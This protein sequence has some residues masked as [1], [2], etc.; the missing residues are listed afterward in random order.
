M[1]S[2]S[3]QAMILLSI[4][5]PCDVD[6]T[7]IHS[8]VTVQSYVFYCH[9]IAGVAHK[10]IIWIAINQHSGGVCVEN[11]AA[12]LSLQEMTDL[13]VFSKQGQTCV[14]VSN[15]KQVGQW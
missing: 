13:Q 9:T 5:K 2:V 12:T 6:C 3:R 4:V 15:R 10:H 7:S 1:H 8:Y 14:N 11:K